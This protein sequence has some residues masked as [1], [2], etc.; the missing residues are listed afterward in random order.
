MSRKVIVE[1]PDELVDSLQKLYEGKAEQEIS[2]EL[3]K[4][5][6]DFIESKLRRMNDPIFESIVTTGSG[7]SDV[8]EHHDKYLYGK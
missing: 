4:A 1:M 5:I 8:S 7:L 3:V 6:R 2:T